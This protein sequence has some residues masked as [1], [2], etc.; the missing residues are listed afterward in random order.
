MKA[1]EKQ[2]SMYLWPN[3]LRII[4][5]CGIFA[6]ISYFIG[7]HRYIQRVFLLILLWAAASSSFNIISGYG[8][9]VVFGY[10]M[11]VGTGAYTTVLL[12]KFLGLSPWFGMW[13]GMIIAVIIALLIGLPT[14]KLHG[15]YFAVTTI[16]FPLIT[17]PI[18]NYMGLE[19]VSIPFIGH[20]STSMQFSDMRSYVLI[21]AALLAVILII[22]EKMEGSRFGF[23]LRALRENETA[24]EGMGI[25][26]YRTKLVAFMLSASLGAMMGTIY[27]F[28]IQYVLT[29]HAMFGL[30]IIVKVLSITIVG[31]YA[32]M[33]GPV[34]GAILL[35]PTGEFLNAQFGGK[36][37]GVQDIIYGIA[38]IISIIYMRE[39][40]WGK[41]RRAFRNLPPKLP[42]S[43][44]SLTIENYKQNSI[45]NLE[46]QD[47]SK[48]KVFQTSNAESN[49]NGAI[50]KIEGVYKSFGGVLALRDVNIEV[51]RG[52]IL[53]IMGPNG[54]GKTTLFNVINGYL[55]PEEGRVIFEGK[56]VTPFKPHVLCKL[57]IG[58][59]FQVAQIFSKMTILEN[60]MIGAF[61]RGDSITKA[62]VIAEKV[63]KEMGLSSRAYDVAIGLTIWE[64]KILELSRALATQPKLLLVDEPMAGL[65]PEETN[66]IGE[67]IK[68]IAK[69]GITVVVIE[70]VVQSLVKI[71]DWMVGLDDGRKVAEGTPKEVTSDPHI[72]EA[73]L[74]A[75]WRERHAKT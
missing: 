5:V 42:P 16:A 51:P 6:L 61:N 45:E 46:N 71:A 27:A 9:Q 54:A 49:T 28:S 36:Y 70:H 13:V 43:I 10:M 35:V 1:E 68:A 17:A 7:P 29:T 65:N 32:T 50:L 30:F 26:A 57:G 69:S 55:T 2:Q 40:I 31:G 33:W 14:L 41:I 67:V 56:D 22:V 58:R 39:G 34:I 63:A 25:N 66:R 21:A 44:E 4:I 20:G 3:Y 11:F 24:A 74:G 23:G 59:T 37:P 19:E 72:I 38:L 48:P 8:G 75:K 18:L 73:Y 64:T 52:K 53:G 15:A 12:F 47:S 62:H 60:I